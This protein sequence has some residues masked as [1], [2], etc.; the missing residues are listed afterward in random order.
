MM[1]RSL[2]ILLKGLV[3]ALI[4][5]YL[6]STISLDLARKVLQDVRFEY[7][8]FAGILYFL[9][10]M[11]SAYKWSLIARPLGFE[12]SYRDFFSYYFIGMFFNLFMLGSIGGDVVKAFYLSSGRRDLVSAGYSIFLDRFTGGLALV[13]I[14]CLASLLEMWRGVFPLFIFLLV[15]LVTSIVWAVTVLT[16]RLLDALSFF[17]RLAWRLGFQRLKVFWDSPRIILL[18][19][20]ISFVF[21]AAFVLIV[22][23]VGKG[24]GMN[25]P[26]RYFFVFVPISDLLSV[27]PITVNGLGLREGIYVFFLKRLGVETSAA[28]MFSFASTAVVWA[29]S[30]VGGGLYMLKDRGLSSSL[31]KGGFREREDEHSASGP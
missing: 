17:K 5:Y 10:Q 13:S 19:L 6:F 21:Q 4:I 15:L 9:G 7:L 25:V 28:V 16:P 24:F 27:L 11:L 26:L 30:L 31:K 8:L 29:V 12:R 22:F 2:K 3:S 18:P 1:P 20:L 14:L 23:T